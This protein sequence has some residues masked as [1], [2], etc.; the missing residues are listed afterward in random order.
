MEAQ[1][2]H[3]VFGVPLCTLLGDRTLSGLDWRRFVA[4]N[5]LVASLLIFIMIFAVIGFVT[6]FV[7]ILWCVIVCRRRK[8]SS[9]YA[10]NID[11][12]AATDS[13]DVKDSSKVTSFCVSFLNNAC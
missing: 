7:A 3:E 6:S 12:G 2:G 8:R 10:P 9:G 13:S 11:Q 4:S 1:A 5:P